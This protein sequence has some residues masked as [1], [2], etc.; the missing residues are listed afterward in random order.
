MDRECPK[1]GGSGKQDCE[2]CEGT[3][4]VSVM[5]VETILDLDSV[6][7]SREI[8]CP[9]CHGSGHQPCSRCD[10]TGTV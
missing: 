3:G 1:C 9:R 5:D 2:K 10:G 7:N 6:S 8:V 4:T